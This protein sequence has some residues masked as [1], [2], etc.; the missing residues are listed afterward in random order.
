[1]RLWIIY[2]NSFGYSRMI[3]EIFESYLEEDFIVSVGNAEIIQPSFVFD[4]KPDLLIFGELC[5][6]VTPDPKIQG[7]I[8]DFIELSNS[9]NFHIKKVAAYCIAVDDKNIENSWMD[10]F[11]KYFQ[12]DQIYPKNLVLKI[13]NLNGS[14][15]K[16]VSLLIKKYVNDLIQFFE[17]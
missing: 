3:S 1:M 9:S 2:V 5:R 12:K 14:L 7:W 16:E 6:E 10:F 15:D 4:E 17:L 13:N 11:G 8:E